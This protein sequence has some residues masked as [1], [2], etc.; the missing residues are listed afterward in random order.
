MNNLKRKT[1][2]GFVW[3]FGERITAQAISLTVSIVLA[4]ILTPDEY[5]VVAIIIIFIALANSLVSSGLGAALVQNRKSTR[6]DFSTMFHASLVLSIVLYFL[7]F[8]AAPLIA[9]IYN[10]DLLVP[11]IRVLGIKIPIASISSIQ[12]AYVTKKM[13][14]KKFFLATI[15]GTIASA[16]V[17]IIMAYNGF[18]AWALVAQYLT[19]STMD[20]II[21][22][23]TID[24]KPTFYFS[25]TKFKEFFSFGWKIMASSFIG[26]LFNHLKGLIIGIK[27]PPEELAFYNRADQ[28]PAIVKD[29]LNVSFESVLFSTLSVLQKDKNKLRDAISKMVKVA[30]FVITPVLIG[31]GATSS[32]IVSIILTDKWLPVVPFMYVFCIQYCFSVLG[33]VNMQ[34]I[35]SIGRS[36]I[37]LKLEFVKKPLFVGFIV[38]GMIFGPFG[39]AVA[40]LLY[41]IVGTTINM[42][43]NNKLVGY[44]IRQQVVDFMP[45]LLVSLAMGGFVYLIG[46]IDINI[47]AKL[48]IQII[49]GVAVYG[50]LS[51][52]FFRD[53]FKDTISMVKTIMKKGK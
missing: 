40:G 53:I 11:L 34:T 19:N 26:T 48:G 6:D 31:L 33:T 35:K 23:L 25:F 14:Y 16:F 20:M 32:S 43:P 9:S 42:I 3:R 27:Y 4:R 1:L 45:F 13:I 30:S 18:G 29:N 41:D 28:F 50:L 17:G 36:D 8:F 15:V 5:G 12:Q 49:S 44:S 38:I 39:I 24:W 7:L 51:L 52:V 10:N 37:I 21:L 2:S 47:Y 46:L 22:G